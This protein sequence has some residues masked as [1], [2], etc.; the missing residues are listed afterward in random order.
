MKTLVSAVVLFTMLGLQGPRS[1]SADEAVRIHLTKTV[2]LAGD[3]IEIGCHVPKP[4]D[5]KWIEIGLDE[6]PPT[7]Y[8]LG[9]KSPTVYLSPPYRIDCDAT[10]AYCAVGSGKNPSAV[11]IQMIRVGGCE[12]VGR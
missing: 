8:Q 2:F 12:G 9:D 11:A 5:H 6:I 10:R 1:I 3:P 4:G 7:T